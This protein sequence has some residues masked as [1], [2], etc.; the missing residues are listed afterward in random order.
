MATRI[1]MK[2]P[3]TGLS[4][5]GFY[6]FSWTTLFFGGFPALFRGDFVTFIGLFA[7]LAI[8]A[9]ATMGIGAFVGSIV[10]AFMYNGF[11]TKKLI[12]KGYRFVGT[13]EEN[14]AAFVALGLKGDHNDNG[15]D[16]AGANANNF[17]RSMQSVKR[18]AGERNVSND[19]YRI[20]L[21]KKFGIEK[22]ITFEKFTVSD[23]VFDDLNSA[24]GHCHLLEEAEIEQTSKFAPKF[25]GDTKWKFRMLENE[26]VEV[27]NPY[28]GVTVYATM[29][30]AKKQLTWWN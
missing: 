25:I 4:K 22:N 8:L 27:I 24:V 21:G 5:D 15:S 14:N 18:F 1:K 7:V 11:Y 13:E 23:R 26:Q 3:S 28:G 30:E 19:Q 2:N 12:E 9:F 20:Y 16:R 6:G 29:D 17:E 10:W